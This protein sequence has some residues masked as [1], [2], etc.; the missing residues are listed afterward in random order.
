MWGATGVLGAVFGWEMTLLA[1]RLQ[2][3]KAL[4]FLCS[5]C[6]GHGLAHWPFENFHLSIF[7]IFENLTEFWLRWV[8]DFE[9]HIGIIQNIWSGLD[10]NSG[11][12]DHHQRFVQF[13]FIIFIIFFGLVC[14]SRISID[15]LVSR[16]RT[17]VFGIWTRS[18][19]RH[20]CRLL[21]TKLTGFKQSRQAFF[22]MVC[23]ARES[24]FQLKLFE[25]LNQKREKK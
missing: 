25:S 8:D 13:S 16:V 10:W 9:P 15:I 7:S 12:G 20:R 6:L 5:P 17:D 21:Q 14:L 2:A 4:K 23:W 1:E 19:M 18:S 22:F 11:L 24:S 3:F